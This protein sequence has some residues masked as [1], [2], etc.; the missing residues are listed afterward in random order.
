MRVSGSRR[1]HQ[2]KESFSSGSL[3]LREAAGRHAVIPRDHLK[4]FALS[5]MFA[6][7]IVLGCTSP[8]L[9]LSPSAVQRLMLVPVSCFL[10]GIVLLFAELD[11]RRANHS[12]KPPITQRIRPES[13]GFAV[14]GTVKTR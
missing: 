2:A 6:I 5:G 9:S 13:W 1:F 3:P 10:F 7:G 14:R 4:S 12:K 8:H 11:K